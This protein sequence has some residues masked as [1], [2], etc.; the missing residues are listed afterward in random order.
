VIGI[1]T[2]V[3]RDVAADY[4]VG[5]VYLSRKRKKNHK[6]RLDWTLSSNEIRATLPAVLPYLRVKKQQAVLLLEYLR[7]ACSERDRTGVYFAKVTQIYKG[8]RLLNH[9]G[10]N[11]GN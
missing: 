1:T 3:I 7:L 11:D 6:D 10:V 9:R 5:K 4:G 2:P 8:L